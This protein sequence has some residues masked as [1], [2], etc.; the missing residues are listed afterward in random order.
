M[1]LCRRLRRASHRGAV[2]RYDHIRELSE[3]GKTLKPKSREITWEPSAA[4]IYTAQPYEQENSFLIVGERLNASGS[5]K[6]RD[7]LN[8]EDWDGLVAMAREQ[9]REGA[10]ILDVNVDYVWPRRRARHERI[11]FPSCD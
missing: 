4:S 2:I 1:A 7:L 8:A 10:H 5:K 11:S 9:V 3:I 6:C